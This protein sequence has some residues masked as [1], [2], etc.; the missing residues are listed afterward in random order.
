MT[1]HSTK[2]AIICLLFVVS[3]VAMMGCISEEH[4]FEKSPGV[5]TIL[6]QNNIISIQEKWREVNSDGTFSYHAKFVSGREVLVEPSLYQNLS[7]NRTGV[8]TEKLG[9]LSSL[10]KNT[11]IAFY[12]TNVTQYQDIKNQVVVIP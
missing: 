8:G 3:S 1:S 11:M 9:G 4:V 2:L 5:G 10:N 12:P 7:I 6:D